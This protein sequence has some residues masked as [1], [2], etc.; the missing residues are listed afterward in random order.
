MAA[1]LI[2]SRDNYLQSPEIQFTAD[3]NVTIQYGRQPWSITLFLIPKINVG[4]MLVL[5]YAF[6]YEH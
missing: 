5:C 3:F 4:F 1:N 6:T 2:H